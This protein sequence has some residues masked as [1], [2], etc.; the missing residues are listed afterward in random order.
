MKKSRKYKFLIL[1][2]ILMFQLFLNGQSINSEVISS[3][4]ISDINNNILLSY[5]IGEPVI[6][7]CYDGNYKLLQGFQKPEINIVLTGFDYQFLALLEGPYE[8]GQM[9][10][11]LNQSG[12][13]PLTQPY[14]AEPWNYTGTENVSEIPNS[15]IVDWA[16]I[17]LRDASGIEF[18]TTDKTISRKACFILNDGSLVDIN[19]SDLL[20]FTGEVSQ[21]LFVVIHHRNHL[22]IISAYPLTKSGNVYAYDFTDSG[23]KAYGGLKAQKELNTGVWSMIAADGNADSQIDNKDKNDIWL[24]QLGETGYK[25]GDYDMN[26]YVESSDKS[27]YWNTNSGKASQIPD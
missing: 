24:Q 18:A 25:Q 6:N 19:G 10:T 14:Y 12:S 7:Y 4:G 26:G 22:D 1:V 5:T 13:L 11:S 2:L 21:K 23:F 20:Q 27:D 16:L 3:S 17:E 9:A 15:N 8:S